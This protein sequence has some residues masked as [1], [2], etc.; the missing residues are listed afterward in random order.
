MACHWLLLW[1]LATDS[2]KQYNGNWTG[3]PYPVGG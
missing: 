3:R 1:V 2:Y